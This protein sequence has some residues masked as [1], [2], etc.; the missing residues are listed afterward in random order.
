MLASRILSPEMQDL[1][2]KRNS[3]VIAISDLPIEWTCINGIPL[4]FTHDVCRMP[5]TPFHG[6]M[7]FYAANN[8]VEYSIPKNILSK[9]LVIL[10]SQDS[11]FL[12]WHDRVHESATLHNF[13]TEK[14]TALAQL[15]SAI[16]KHRPELLIFDCHGGVD[17]ETKSTFLWIGDQKLTGQYAIEHSIYAPIVFISA[18]GTAPTYGAYNSIANAFFE[19]GA[20]ATTTTYIPIG[21]DSGSFLYLRILEKLAFIADNVIHKNWLEF[22][23]HVIRTSTMSDTYLKLLNNC[24][25]T[26]DEFIKSQTQA[27]QNSLF[28]SKRRDLYGEL[29]RHIQ[30]LTRDKKMHYSETVPEYLLYSTLGRADLIIFEN[31]REKFIELNSPEP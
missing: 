13:R 4:S 15:K 14:C 8:T 30:S 16:E 27:V 24:T 28:F 6:L 1:I 2:Q 5:E 3:Q 23:C 26:R 18:C 21:I 25:F 11:P 19:A 7:S 29:D 31:W 22:I 12:F 20:L 17:E 9:T 10:G